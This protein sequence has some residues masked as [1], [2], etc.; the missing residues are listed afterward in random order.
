MKVVVS[1]HPAKL[2]EAMKKRA[3]EVEHALDVLLPLPDGQEKRLIEAMRYAVLGGGKRLR[4]FLVMEVAA[5]FSRRTGLRRPRRRLGRDAA[6]LF[7]GA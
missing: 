2:G 1:E 3:Q 6:R 7:A 5:L 4:G